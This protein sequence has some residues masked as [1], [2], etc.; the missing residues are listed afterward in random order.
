MLSVVFFVYSY[1]NTVRAAT[2][3][4]HTIGRSTDGNGFTTSAIDTT[5]A[6]F[7]VIGLSTAN[8][9]GT[10]SIS[11]NK[12]NTWIPLT[13]WIGGASDRQFQFFYCQSC[14][15][16]TGHTFTDTSTNT[17]P[18]LMVAAFSGIATVPFDQQNGNGVLFTTSISTNSVT[19]TVGGELVIAGLTYDDS[20]T[21]TIDSGF[22]IID[23]SVGGP[24]GAQGGQ[25]AYLIQTTATPENPTFTWTSSSR[26]AAG[27][28]TFASSGF[29]GPTRAIVT[30]MRGTVTQMSGTVTQ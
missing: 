23:T 1:T 28:A 3:I 27:I 30:Q 11:D 16:G 5:G 25:M 18:I 29:V 6:N 4:A 13:Q 26:A 2:L 21:P 12:G 9:G 24:F 22:T 19:P 8:N 17:F 10:D 20:S 7:I 14:T 15:V